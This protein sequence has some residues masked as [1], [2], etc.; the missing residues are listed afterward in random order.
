ML[1]VLDK[2]RFENH[3]LTISP[4][5]KDQLSSHILAHV[6]KVEISVLVLSG[7]VAGAMKHG[8]PLQPLQWL[9]RYVK[10]HFK[11]EPRTVCL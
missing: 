2:K 6:Q 8:P 9:L 1:G 7:A 3:C 10:S 11:I 5:K 4:P